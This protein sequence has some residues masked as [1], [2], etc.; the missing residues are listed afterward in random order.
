MSVSRVASSGVVLRRVALS[1]TAFCCAVA[2]AA[3]TL[4]GST[5]VRAD[6]VPVYGGGTFDAD[7]FNGYTNQGIFRSNP[8]VVS[9]GV[10]FS[11]TNPEV[12]GTQSGT[13][14]Q[15]ITPAGFTLLGALG[16]SSSGTTSAFP[17][18][19]NASG[20]V[21]GFSEKYDSGHTDL[22]MRPVVWKAGSTTPTELFVPTAAS[23]LGK[24]IAF[25]VGADGTA[26]GYYTINPD[27]GSPFSPGADIPVK[28]D[29]AGNAT[30]LSTLGYTTTGSYSLYGQTG[31]VAMNAS[32]VIIGNLSTTVGARAAKWDAAGVGTELLPLVAGQTST[33]SAINNAGTSVGRT[34]ADVANSRS[35]AVSWN[36]A[37]VPTS[38]AAPAG[39]A[40][41]YESSANAINSSGV[42]V[43]TQS[44]TNTSD[45]R[46]MRWAADGTPTVL[47]I[48]NLSPSGTANGS[49]YDINDAGIAVGT[50]SLYTG[51]V[52]ASRA[53]AWL[54]SGVPVDLNSLIDPASGWTLTQA[55]GITNDDWV[56]GV[57]SFDPDGSG[58]A[59][60][61]TRAFLIQIPSSALVVPEP[62]TAMLAMPVAGLLVRRRRA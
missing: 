48:Y 38:L 35:H 61:Y 21:A 3:V 60:A 44:I 40:A 14:P 11:Y 4:M 43:G 13:V 20:A 57:G 31:A 53:T 54:T 23:G 59:A 45:T 47:G 37:G 41:N 12:D 8:K 49:A 22:G 36:A 28:W 58:P 42:A 30:A 32:G 50:L 26:L 39:V 1:R 15:L 46:P 10:G 56:S 62:S 51:G 18:A 6:T 2:A 34:L 19:I 5:L 25:N 17:L 27:Q 24:G 55:E 29:S 52:G 7:N 9:S 33:V 16:T